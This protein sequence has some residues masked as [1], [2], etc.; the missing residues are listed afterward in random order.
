[1]YSQEPSH[2]VSRDNDIK[3][4]ASELI[5]KYNKKPKDKQKPLFGQSFRNE[6]QPS[7]G[8]KMFN[9]LLKNEK[10]QTIQ[11]AS[12]YTGMSPGKS[13]DKKSPEKKPGLNSFKNYTKSTKKP[14]KTFVTLHEEAKKTTESLMQPS[15]SHQVLPSSKAQSNNSS[16]FG[17]NRYNQYQPV[18]SSLEKKKGTLSKEFKNPYL[19]LG[20]SATSNSKATLKSG[21][22][23]KVPVSEIEVEVTIQEKKKVQPVDTPNSEEDSPPRDEKSPSHSHSSESQKREYEGMKEIIEKQN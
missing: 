11:P 16:P 22:K 18:Q 5:N 8:M 6:Q 23:K 13:E 10:S 15:K 17:K 12:E 19:N 14:K 7:E 1:M 4:F 3:S 20:R 9:Q 21:T 2:E